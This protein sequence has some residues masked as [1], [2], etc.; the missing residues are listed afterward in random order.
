MHSKVGPYA[1]TVLITGLPA[2]AIL[3]IH[4]EPYQITITHTAQGDVAQWVGRT[5]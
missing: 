5:L 1:G 3:D 4:G 2:S